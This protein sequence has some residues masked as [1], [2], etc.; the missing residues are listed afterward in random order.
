MRRSNADV[1]WYVQRLKITAREDGD[2]VT[3]REKSVRIFKLTAVFLCAVLMLA[4]GALCVCADETYIISGFSGKDSVS[5]LPGD[6]V[7]AAR[8][9]EVSFEQDG[10]TYA[11]SCL[12]AVGTY[13][14]RDTIRAVRANFTEPLDLSEYLAISFDVYAPALSADS[15]AVFFARLTLV[16]QNGDT[17]EHLEIIEGGR[18][19]HIEAYIGSWEARSGIVEAEIAVAIDTSLAGN[20]VERFYVDD[21]CASDPVDRDMTQRFLFDSYKVQGGSAVLDADKSKISIVSETDGMLTLEAEVFAPK[22]NYSLNCLRL[23]FANNTA[24]DTLTLHYSTT[25]SQVTTEDKIVTVPIK[26]YSDVYDYFVFVGD[27]AQLQSIKLIFNSAIGE[28]ELVSINAISAYEPIEYTTCGSLNSCTV[29]EELATVTFSGEVNRETAIVNRN[30]HIAIFAYD[31]KE[32][33]TK[34][35]LSGL[36]PLVKT[37]MTTRFELSWRV[38]TDGSYGIDTRFIAVCV[39][40]SGEYSLICPPFYIQNA[41]D[42]AEKGVALIPDAKAFSSND[43]SAVGEVGASLTLLELDAEKLFVEKSEASPY[44]YRG[45]AYYFDGEYLK[46]LESKADVLNADGVQVLLRLYGWEITDTERLDE[47]YA[48]DTY[49]DYSKVTRYSDGSDYIA[50]IGSYIAENLVSD[51]KIVGVVFGEGENIFSG[52]SSLSEMVDHTADCLRTLY[53]ELVRINPAVKLYISLTDLYSAEEHF[54][55]GE[56]G[57]DI[58]LPALI[59]HTAK[60]GQFPWELSLEKVYRVAGSSR[61]L[62]SV[63]TVGAVRWLLEMSGAADKHIIFIDHTY[64]AFASSKTENMQNYVL[65]T[66]GALFCDYVDAYIGATGAR[67]GELVDSAKYI[68]TDKAYN[69]ENIV[70]SEFEIEDFSEVISGFDAGAVPKMRLVSSAAGFDKPSNILGSYSYYRFDGVSSIGGLSPSYYSGALR[71]TN[72]GGNVLSVDLDASRFGDASS[73]YLLGIG[74]NFDITEDL[75]LTPTLSITLKIDGVS[76]EFAMAAAVKVVLKGESERFEATADVPVGEWT[77]LYVDTYG[78]KEL[79]DTKSLQIFVSGEDVS[80]ATLKI[81]SI[82]GLSSEYNDDSL[83]RVIEKTRAKKIDSDAGINYLT[84]WPI[85][86]GVIVVITTVVILVMLSKRR[87]K[88]NE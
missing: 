31:E 62:V 75:S 4:F 6:N 8:L 46:S 80:K 35:E 52:Q 19:N 55:G 41:G 48:N 27:A 88:E 20:S 67:S 77:T 57:L 69:V 63:D 76:P 58:Y 60:Y 17:T 53:F 56:V 59:E 73:A 84:Y 54:D 32:L 45:K 12:E 72:D 81:R 26:P 5:W 83:A 68:F 33:P 18:W 25:D 16:S 79:K 50:A 3:K 30:G 23:R 2:G 34:E 10:S 29:S 85:A 28:I 24:S 22:V 38:P 42:I 11:R 9:T 49:V 87:Y 47:F 7:L 66:Y 14:P 36:T 21:I 37:Q 13:A 39:D 61:E 1:L 71:V 74:H 51:G 82:D 44:I 78:F 64:F 65:G 40:E 86:L 43:I 15:D 70:K